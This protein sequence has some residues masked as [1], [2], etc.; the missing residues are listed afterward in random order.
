MRKAFLLLISS[1][2]VLAGCGSSS[3]SNRLSDPDPVDVTT[4]DF[5]VVHASQDAPPVNLT[6][7]G[8]T[9]ASGAD[10]GDAAFVTTT[11]GEI[12]ASASALLG[13]TMNSS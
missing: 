13:C 4:V 6:V 1:V 8:T 12:T 5:E 10:F 9:I 7:G 11:A 3:S 2:W